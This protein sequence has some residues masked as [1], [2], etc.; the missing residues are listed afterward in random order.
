MKKEND[1]ILALQSSMSATLDTSEMVDKYLTFWIDR[2]L[3]SVP[4]IDVVQIIGVLEITPVPNFP[5]FAKG[6]INIRGAIIPIIDMRLR[7]G[8]PEKEYDTHTCFIIVQIEET[9]IGF[10][11]DEVAEVATITKDMIS[12]LPGFSARFD[13]NY[14]TGAGKI[15]SSIVLMLDAHHILSNDQLKM[16]SQAC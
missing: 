15:G 9:T 2:Q 13:Q 16:L 6:I 14:L 12:S 1:Q 10:I 8:R 4:I 5:A 3:F 11:V 7:L